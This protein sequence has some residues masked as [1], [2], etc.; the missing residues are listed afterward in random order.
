M[1]LCIFCIYRCCVE[2]LLLADFINFIL[3][4]DVAF[5]ANTNLPIKVV[6][7]NLIENVCTSPLGC[8]FGESNYWL[9]IFLLRLHPFIIILFTPVLRLLW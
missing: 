5:P 4:F 8:Q 6:M 1:S 3:T 2:E 7:V 9:A